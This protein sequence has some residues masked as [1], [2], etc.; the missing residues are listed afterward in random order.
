MF[1]YQRVQDIEWLFEI[2]NFSLLDGWFVEVPFTL[3]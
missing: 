1:D 2:T 3:E